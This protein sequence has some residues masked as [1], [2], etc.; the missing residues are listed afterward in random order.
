M[1]AGSRGRS[2]ST[3]QESGEGG[4]PSIAPS[5]CTNIILFSHA[6]TPG[7]RH[8]SRRQH[9]SYIVQIPLGHKARERTSPSPPSPDVS[10]PVHAVTPPPRPSSALLNLALLVHPPSFFCLLLPFR[11]PIAQARPRTL[12]L[13]RTTPPPS[14]PS[15]RMACDVPACYR[16]WQGQHS[17]P[18]FPHQIDRMVYPTL[19]FTPQYW[20]FPACLYAFP[21]RPLFSHPDRWHLHSG[22]T[23]DG[24]NFRPRARSSI[25]R[26]STSLT[27]SQE[28]A[29]IRPS[30]TAYHTHRP[31]R[32]SL[33]LPIRSLC[34]ITCRQC[35]C[36]PSAPIHPDRGSRRRPDQ[37]LSRF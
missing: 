22:E 8:S 19:S 26:P 4:V 5:L 6:P 16:P 20:S 27:R 29:H 15:P 25:T 18:V 23:G 10:P 28:M 32:K 33:I 13:T 21:A 3:K 35:A 2:R 12:V 31:L 14:P 30:R 1:Q 11:V 9:S 24:P 36:S 37:P 34:G 7:N 17:P